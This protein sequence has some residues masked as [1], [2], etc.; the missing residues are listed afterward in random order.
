MRSLKARIPNRGSKLQFSVSRHIP[1]EAPLEKMHYKTEVHRNAVSAFADIQNPKQKPN[2]QIF[3][4]QHFS[5]G[6]PIE[7]IRYQTEIHQKFAYALAETQN[8][9]Q[10]LNI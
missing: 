2:I 8:P 1:A 7:S 3:V 9:K 5:T 6:A 10:R 4:S